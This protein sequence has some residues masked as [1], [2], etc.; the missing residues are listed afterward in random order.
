MPLSNGTRLGGYEILSA[1]GAGGMGEVYRA[2]DTRL[3]RDVAIKILPQAFFADAE[4]VA[5]FQREAKV[6][7]SLNHPH[8]AAIYGLHDEGDGV[9][10]LAMELVEG[11]DLK[12]R[13]TRGPIPLDEALPI[14]HQIAQA[15]E[16]AHGQGIIHRDLKPAN[17]MLRADD[18]VKVLDFGLAKAVGSDPGRPELFDSP[19]V[20]AVATRA[21]TI[22]GTAPY[23]SPEQAKGRS[24][25]RRTDLW[26]FGVVLYE[27]LTGTRAF[28][29]ES[30][31]ETLSHVLTHTP[32]WAL[33]PADTPAPIRTLL[34]RC[35]E[36]N[37]AK[38]L[39]SAAAV[40]LEIDDALAAPAG[41]IT[42]TSAPQAQRRRVTPKA[43]A[44]VVA[45][46]LVTALGT[47]AV[48]RSEPPAPALA[49][50]FSITF[51]P[52][53]PMDFNFGRDLALSPDGRYLAYQSRGRLML[54]A[55][56]Q[57][58]GVPLSNVRGRTPFF[59]PDSR[60]IGFFDG[61]ELK[62][63]AVTGE[64]V[65]T[66]S[67][68]LGHPLGGSG[69]WG[70]DGTIVV[71]SPSIADRTIGLR[72]ISADGGEVSVLT[73]VDGAH[74][75]GIPS[76]L[77]GGRGVLFTIRTISTGDRH[78]AALDLK[79]GEQKTV[80]PRGFDGQYLDT[81]HLIYAMA[82]SQGSSGPAFATL[83]VVG[84]DLD[85]LEVRGDPVRVG[86]GLQVDMPAAVNY[87]VSRSGVLAY[88]PA[89]GQLRSF[90]WVDRT[91]RET[92]IDALPPGQYSTVGLSSDGRRVAFSIA[93]RGSEISVFDFA[94]G[95][96][97][98]VTVDRKF[99]VL[100]RWAPDGQRIV[101]QSNH[102]GPLNL[103]SVAPDGTGQITRLTNSSNEQYPNSITRDGTI[104]FAEPRPTSGFDIFRLPVS[105][106]QGA[107]RTNPADDRL[108]EATELVSTASHE[109]AANISPNGRYFAYQ[110][111]VSDGRF[112]VYVRAYPDASRGPWQISTGGGSTPVWAHSGRELFYLDESNTLMAAPVDTLGPQFSVG[113]PAKVFDTKYW[114]NF[115]SYDVTPEGRF[116]MLK[117]V[118]QSQASIVV[119]LNWF[120]ELSRRLPTR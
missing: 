14:A 99:A 46:S 69:T 34:R 95:T 88:V 10:A 31:A 116:L 19:T 109:Y 81:G 85:G 53:E 17:I 64:P 60:W 7:A 9:R 114:G 89:R 82:G 75:H 90:V 24:V 84:F 72:R 18:T 103:Y 20:T 48:M 71:S 78:L 4:R 1:L 102:D 113:R 119:V 41:V 11:E 110:A 115:Y 61:G 3:D 47:W 104:L 91:G 5:R 100:P 30:V 25:D 43:I 8:I 120:E 15:L 67:P 2:R 76:M 51:P 97:T 35:L 40:R 98:R 50:R 29:G 58:D 28:Q 66:L 56:D 63:V 21:G 105:A 77:P 13:L 96:S 93:D 73:R 94:R 70:D 87:A 52:T 39:D 108:P 26:A 101:F 112:A 55:L 54:R 32:D 107:A 49:V 16:A 27:L 62:K 65:I 59:S 92:A 106:P 117:D 80:V 37:P 83:W 12:Q 118:G 45:A 44:A 111:A 74:L 23:M 33:L 57:L 38:R 36:K 6:L 79:S 86:E 42:T 68:E 22:L